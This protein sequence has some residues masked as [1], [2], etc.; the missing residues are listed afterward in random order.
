M[1]DPHNESMKICM[2]DYARK[3]VSELSVA[4]VAGK[5]AEGSLEIPVW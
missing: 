4:R 5:V 3:H 1:T 2:Q